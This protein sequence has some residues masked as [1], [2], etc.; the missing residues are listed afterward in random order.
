[1]ANLNQQ[2]QTLKTEPENPFLEDE[3]D[4]VAEGIPQPED[5]F[6]QK[7]FQGRDALIEEEKKQRSDHAFRQS[8]SPAGLEAD[9]IVSRVR[10]EERL[11]VW[12]AHFE[13]GLSQEPAGSI[14]PG[15]MYALAKERMQKTKLWEIV[16]RM[17][18]GALLHAHLDAMIDL[19]F[20]FEMALS[21]PG[22]H[23]S[24]PLALPTTEGRESAS[25]RFIYSNTQLITSGDIWTEQYRP[26]TLVPIVLAAEN[27]PGGRTAFL[28][29]LKQRCTITAEESLE[30]HHGVD[31]IWKKFTSTFAIIGS[32]LFYE[33]I[34]R[35]SVYRVCQQLS[36]DGIRYVD[37]R[38]AFVHEYRKEGHDEP[39][40]G[41]FEVMRVFGEEINRFK[42]S[43]EGKSFWG[44][45]MIWTT[46]R[47]FDN[48][49]IAESMEDCI[50]VKLAYPHLIAGF[51]LVG[52]EDL[53]RPLTSLTPLL[54][55]FRKRCAEEGVTLP[56]FFHAG[57]CL[58]DGDE[59]DHNLF[60]AILLGTRRLGH[61]FSLYKHPLLIDHVRE[62]R[63]LIES[64]PISN[65]ILRL[66]SSISAHPLPALLA[67]GVPVALCNDDPAILGHEGNGL[68]GDFWQAVQAW[69]NLGLAGLG[70]LAENSVRWAAF[71]DQSDAEWGKD[72]REGSA[73]TGIRAKRL[74]EWMGEWERFCLWVVET[75]G[76]EVGG[77][78]TQQAEDDGG[79]EQETVKGSVKEKENEKE[80]EKE[81]GRESEKK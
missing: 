9:A 49:Q 36:E 41:Y 12:S 7:Y 26:F 16:R 42:A 74:R 45:R 54:F 72:V 68:S 50:A 6:I 2:Y 19:D 4:E 81:G 77:E 44:A 13:D 53:G 66:T 24:S 43:E 10:R 3:W 31:A 22:M 64:C 8:L 76:D 60:S 39:E 67:R 48:R 56:F 14:F 5:P 15:M 46:L 78:Q 73:G 65:E 20:L 32:I 47:F 29:W 18:K 25:I 71:E 55:W 80:S 37:F 11:T 33:P 27:F 35:A 51:D 1:M 62:K 69:E 59:T 17:P 21:T 23:I 63:I 38:V 75:Y 70:S 58:G 34:F 52:Q 28:A 40:E 61:A 79:G 57:E 30:H